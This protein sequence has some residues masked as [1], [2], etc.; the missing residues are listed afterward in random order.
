MV[1]TYPEA[2]EALILAQDRFVWEVPSFEKR[3]R[4]RR[5]YLF[6][7]LLA[8]FLVAYAIY[9]ANFLFAFLIVLM[10]ILL[11]LTGRQ[12]PV[13]M[14]VQIGDNGIV[15][16]GK[17]H[18]YQ[19]LDTFSII[20]QPPLVK[21]LYIET[22][23]ILVPRLRISLNDQDPV[24]IRSLLKQYLKEDLDLRGEYVSDIIGRLLRI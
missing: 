8:T 19:D 12:E 9:T 2:A 22:R 16:N 13:P 14:L 23:N 20:Y 1:P 7:L 11:L 17:L 6:M 21:V 24:G 18:L 5:W 3:E 15:V 10:A 4:G